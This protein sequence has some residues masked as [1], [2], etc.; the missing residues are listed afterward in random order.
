VASRDRHAVP[1]DR[2]DKG[3]T[4]PGGVTT[5][6]RSGPVQNLEPVAGPLLNRGPKFVN[7]PH[8]FG[9]PCLAELRWSDEQ[10]INIAAHI[11]VA[12]RRRAEEHGRCKRR[13]PSGECS[14]QAPRE[15]TIR[16]EQRGHG[17]VQDMVVVERVHDPPADVLGQTHAVC[18]QALRSP[19]DSCLRS[20]PSNASQL[21]SR[22]RG[23]PTG[24][25]RNMGIVRPPANPRPGSDKSTA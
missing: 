14:P 25:D 6:D 21:C 20:D 10:Q 16:L 24:S 9:L 4:R 8:P 13:F 1:E 23:R 17:V 12:S 15:L 18:S 11:T 7:L 2:V 3:F 19:P 5:Q 22:D